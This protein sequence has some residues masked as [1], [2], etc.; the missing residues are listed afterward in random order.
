MKYV[1]SLNNALHEM[2]AE[3]NQVILLGEDI[4]DPY[5]GAFKVSKGLSTKF[6][7]QVISTPISEQAII[8][9]AIGMAM[10]GM[11]PIVEIMFGDFITLCMD[12]IIN[13]ATKYNWMYN[14]QVNVPLVI[15]TSMG[16][17]RGYGPTHSQT[18]ENLFMSVPNLKI[19]A[20]SIF[21]DPGEILKKC[22]LE[23][24]DPILF[25]ESKISY[26][27]ELILNDTYDILNIRREKGL[28][29]QI[30][31]L[32]VYP[33]EQPDVTII[34]YGRMGEIAAQAAIDLFM[35][36]EILVE[37]IITCP[38]KPFPLKIILP[39]IMKSGRILTLEEGF[40][41]GGWGAEA[42]YQ[43]QSEALLTLKNPI[44]VIGAKESPIA[45]SI[46]LENEI[47]PSVD[48][49]K[50]EVKKLLK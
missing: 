50:K 48:L 20:P 28:N 33:K 29:Y 31:Y 39:N 26:P 36:E 15:R 30:I 1:K 40:S 8:G 35:E 21:H 34:T 49:V 13:H 6:P 18:L 9:S 5:G 16:G 17:G 41:Y 25:I 24:N 14:N 19:A 11:K 10:K 44:K 22:I 12:Q 27:K 23:S 37:V 38:M 46:L 4:A 42:C 7:N 43:I 47:L 32:N 45:N 3:N 2:M